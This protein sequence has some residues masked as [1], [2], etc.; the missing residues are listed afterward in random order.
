MKR[1]RSFFIYIIP[2]GNVDSQNTMCYFK[3]SKRSG[4]LNESTEPQIR[5]DDEFIMK[6]T[7]TTMKKTIAIMMMIATLVSLVACGAAEPKDASNATNSE[8]MQASGN[9]ATSE[10]DKPGEQG[11]NSTG[12]T[13]EPA[14][15]TSEAADPSTQAST[16]DPTTEP[17][18]D[19]TEPTQPSESQPTEPTSQPTQPTTPTQPQPTDPPHQHDYSTTTVVAPTCNDKGY[20]K[21]TCACGD[22]YKDNYTDALG[23]HFIDEV[24]AP[25]STEKGYTKHTCDRCWYSYCDTYTDPVKMVYDAA[26]VQQAGNNYIASLGYTVDESLVWDT[27][28]YYPPAVVSGFELGLP[29]GGQEWLNNSA[30]ECVD[31]TIKRLIVTEPSGDITG[32][33]LFCSVTYNAE[34]DKYRITVYYG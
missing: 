13:G 14:T 32:M 28:G 18:S 7:N 31:V 33:R 10:G 15:G 24:V 25:T 8:Q 5:K 30:I 29:G 23:H 22:S 4:T 26:Q 1:E 2:A 17:G 21:H 11:E 16:A 34:T 19:K 20:T 3:S 27:H 9:V 12:Q 6:K